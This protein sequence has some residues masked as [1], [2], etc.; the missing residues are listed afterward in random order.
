MGL[1]T[2]HDA[3]HG[4][5]SAFNTF[6]QA[7]AHAIGGSYGPHYLRAYGGELARDERGYPI[8]DRSLDDS[9]FYFPNTLTKEGNPGLWEFFHHSDCDGEISPQACVHVADEMEAILP[10]ITDDIRA[11][12]IAARGGMIE[13]TKKFIAGCRAA[14]AAG[15]PLGFH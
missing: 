2:T 10:K 4:A 13:V 8:P 14:A 5:Y 3:F 11:G 1:D 7:I 12:H 15:E 6:R 9:L